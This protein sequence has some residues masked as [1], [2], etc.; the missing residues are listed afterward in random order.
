M[1]VRL[2]VL[3]FW[4]RVPM[5]NPLRIVESSRAKKNVAR[6]AVPSAWGCCAV[7]GALGESRGRARAYWGA[8]GLI[9]WLRGAPGTLGD[10]GWVLALLLQGAQPVDFLISRRPA[11]KLGERKQ[12]GRRRAAWAG[13]HGVQRGERGCGCG[14]CG[15][16]ASAGGGRSVSSLPTNIRKIGTLKSRTPDTPG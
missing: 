1:I 14:C 7:G 5:A 10:P 16:Q 8:L 6:P 2:W 4:W 12:M 13:P 11:E 9:H 3:R 15:A